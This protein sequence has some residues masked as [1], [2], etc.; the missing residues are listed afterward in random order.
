MPERLVQ[1]E[2]HRRSVLRALLWITLVAGMVFAVIN[3][4]RG[5]Y[6]LAGLEVAYALFAG[7]LLTII[8]TTRHLW[9]WTVAYLVPFF[10]IMEYALVLPNTSFTVFAWIQT[11]PIISY[12]L[13]GRRGGF[14]MSLVFIGLGV[15]AFNVR[16]LS[17]DTAL[18]QMVVVANIGFSSLAMMV[19]SHIYERSRVDN[20]LRLIE[21]AGTDSL[22]GLANRMRLADEFGRMRSQVERSDQA[23]SLVVLDLDWFKRL[24][25]RFGHE[26]GDRALKHT[27]KLLAARLRESD[28]ACRIGGEEFALLLPGATLSQ[29]AEL[30]DGLRGQLAQAPLLVGEEEV[31]ITFSAGVATLGEDGADLSALLRTAD[32]RMYEAKHSGRDQVVAAGQRYPL[33]AEL[34]GTAVTERLAAAD[35]A[36]P[37]E[38]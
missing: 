18:L 26:V 29:A 35:K 36:A 25:D 12:L 5:L 15:L 23:L 17:G 30:A 1:S 13:L 8:G 7:G 20:E 4:S 14:W 22:T 31:L 34:A 11:I 33:G 19:F 3:F 28:L 37:P 32:R 6:V 24:N 10:C 2:E 27:A 21:L 16:Y 9:R 38:G